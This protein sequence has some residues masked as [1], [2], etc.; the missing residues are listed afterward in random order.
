MGRRLAWIEAARTLNCVLVVLVH[1]NIYTRAGVET[2]WPGGFF[3]VPVFSLAV[4]SF[5]VIAGYAVDLAAAGRVSSFRDSVPRLRRLVIPFL[6]WNLITLLVFAEPGQSAKQVVFQL[7]TGTWHLY[8]IFA[9]LQLLAIHALLLPALDAGKT[10]QALIAAL[11]L[12]I[13]AFAISELF[14]WIQEPD[15]GTVEALVRRFFVFWA[16]FFALGVWWRRRRTIRLDPALVSIAL[17]AAFALYIIDL[18][19][20]VSA[21]G[22]TPRKQLLFG[23]LPF[24]LLGAVS[25]LALLEHLDATHRARRFIDTLAPW[26]RDT[27]GV[28]LAHITVL[29]LLF[30]FLLWS[31]WLTMHWIQV[32]LLT[33][34]TYLISLALVR[35]VRRLQMEPLTA[36]LIGERAHVDIST[37]RGK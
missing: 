7:L 18:K 2:W 23:G 8:F 21:F 32:P 17:V 5:F 3:S 27:Y 10:R 12:T 37:S 28:Y 30:R 29:L 4:P 19:L 26:G 35:G 13:A 6:A 14:I 34:A 36:L 31:G 33:A 20:E 15:N 9:L 25:L 11:G 1:V 16:G 22:S 24:Q